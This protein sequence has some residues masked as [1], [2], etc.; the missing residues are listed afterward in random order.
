MVPFGGGSNLSVLNYKRQKACIDW[1]NRSNYFFYH[2]KL[3][4]LEKNR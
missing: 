1:K 4:F 3:I 2:T